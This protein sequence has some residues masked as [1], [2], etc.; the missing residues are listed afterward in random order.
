MIG[1]VRGKIVDSSAASCTGGRGRTPRGRWSLFNHAV[2]WLRK[3]RV[4]LPGPDGCRAALVRGGNPRRVIARAALAEL[5]VVPEG[6]RVSELERLRTPPTKSTGTAMVRAMEQ[7]EEI[8]IRQAYRKGRRTSSPPST[9][10]SMP[11]C[12]EIRAPWTRLSP[13]FAPRATTSRTRTS[14]ASPRSRSGISTSWAATC[15]TS[16]PALRPLRGPD[17][18]VDAD[19]EQP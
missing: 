7:V 3:K 5:L 14:P 13:S 2:T 1:L 9:W 6:N 11:L 17:T 19:D 16:N 8:R 15:S 18:A 12:G 4:P 10:S